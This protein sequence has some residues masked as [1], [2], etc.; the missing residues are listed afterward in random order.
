MFL[1]AVFGLVWT[2]VSTEEHYVR[3]LE[4][5][6]VEAYLEF[7]IDTIRNNIYFLENV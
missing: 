6:Y 3:L 4:L 2:A 1:R 7:D 5:L